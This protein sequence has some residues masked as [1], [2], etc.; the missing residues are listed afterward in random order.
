MWCNVYNF[1]NVKL[2]RV[3][4]YSRLQQQSWSGVDILDHNERKV[5]QQEHKVE[6]SGSGWKEVKS[7]RVR[8]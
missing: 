2:F 1:F 5:W 8:L 7:I 6:V 3:V 4:V